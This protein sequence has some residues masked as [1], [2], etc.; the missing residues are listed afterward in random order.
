MSRSQDP[1]RAL[2][3]EKTRREAPLTSGINSWKRN[4]TKSMGIGKNRGQQDD[5]IA[6]MSPPQNKQRTRRTAPNMDGE[7]PRTNGHGSSQSSNGTTYQS[8]NAPSAAQTEAN[9]GPLAQELRDASEKLSNIQE[10]IQAITTSCIQHADDIIR[11]PEVQGKYENLRKEVEDKDVAIANLENALDVL[12]L[13]ASKKEEIAAK[14]AEANLAEKERLDKKKTELDQLKRDAT[15]ELRDKEE[16][17]KAEAIRTISQ[18]AKEQDKKHMAKMKDVETDLEKRKKGQEEELGNLKAKAKEDFETISGLNEQAKELRRQLKDE[19]AKLKDIDRAKEGYKKGEEQLE[20]KLKDL[21]NEFSLNSEPLEYYQGEFFNISRAIQNISYQY[22]A[23]ELNDKEM[24]NLPGIIPGADSTFSDVPFSNSATSQLLRIAH[25]QRVIANAVYRI[26][27]QPFSS[28]VT[29]ADSKFSGFLQDIGAAAG[30]SRS[31]DVW[32]AVTM[33]A[34][35]SMSAANTQL[36]HSLSQ[37]LSATQPITSREDKLVELVLSVLDPLLDTSN[38]PQFKADLLQIAKQAISVWT[39]AQADERT[40][41]INFKLNQENKRDWKIATLD[42][43]PLY[44]DGGIHSVGPR[45]RIPTSIFTLFPIITATKRVQAEKSADGPPG[46]WPSQDQQQALNAEVMIVHDGLGLPQESE[47]VQEGVQEMEEFK[48]MKL[49]HDEL[50]NQKFA[51]RSAEKSHTRNNSVAET[52]SGPPS[53]S[54][55][56]SKNKLNNHKTGN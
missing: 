11:I 48:K 17:L 6:G 7:Q 23:R 19:V 9:L 16:E 27:W 24:A 41:S 21:K 36:R 3:A 14:D 47:L 29:S 46:S 51:Q 40:F 8:S 42:Y 39:S 38:L 2:R 30:S 37:T 52:I 31:A 10:A 53:P 28:D 44:A 5:A 12:E 1:A 13:R 45:R 33:R 35:E 49:E 18:R 32:R 55:S 4:L 15:K 20:E 54:E 43:V 56:W 22:L 25:S 34:L 50:W 26:V